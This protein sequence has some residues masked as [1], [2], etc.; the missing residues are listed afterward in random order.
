LTTATT[1]FVDGLSCGS[2]A[3]AALIAP[4]TGQ[5]APE[6]PG[7]SAAFRAVPIIK[8]LDRREVGRLFPAGRPFHQPHEASAVVAQPLLPAE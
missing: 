2:L 3:V 5:H 4:E 7:P 1:K 8:M 6:L